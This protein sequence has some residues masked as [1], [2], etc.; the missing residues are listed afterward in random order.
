MMYLRKVSIAVLMWLSVAS[1]ATSALAG[2]GV[3]FDQACNTDSILASPYTP[4]MIYIVLIDSPTAS[5][6]GVRVAYS[7]SGSS[8][9]SQSVMRLSQNV[10]GATGTVSEDAMAGECWLSWATPRP[11]GYA[12][13]LLS[14]TLMVTDYSAYRVNLAESPGTEH[15]DNL[16]EISDAGVSY[17]VPVLLACFGYGQAS[18][19]INEHCPLPLESMQ[20]GSAKLMYR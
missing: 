1:C 12:L 14:W 8:Q 15:P 13:P 18:A 10:Y 19:L 17:G 16:P 6:D 7:I 4:F 5:V 3:Y 9:G 2:L 11:S 20:W